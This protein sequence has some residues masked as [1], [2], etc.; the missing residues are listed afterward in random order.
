MP[1]ICEFR[2]KKYID[3]TKFVINMK[4]R[5]RTHMNNINVITG[6]NKTGVYRLLYKIQVRLVWMNSFLYLNNKI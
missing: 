3:A 1:K 5:E 4:W 6:N 2:I